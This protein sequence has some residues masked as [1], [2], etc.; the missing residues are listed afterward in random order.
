VAQPSSEKP[1]RTCS[2]GGPQFP[3]LPR[4]ITRP[5]SIPAHPAHAWPME[6]VTG[7]T[8]PLVPIR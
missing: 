4:R 7:S 8:S 5:P 6:P 3:G 2:T 1:P